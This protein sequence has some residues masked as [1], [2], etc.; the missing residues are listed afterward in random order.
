MS[1]SGTLLVVVGELVLA[2]NV[3]RLDTGLR[4]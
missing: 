4:P 1:W 2:S 3:G